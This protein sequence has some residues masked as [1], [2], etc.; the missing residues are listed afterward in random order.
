MQNKCSFCV[1]VL[2][3]KEEDFVKIQNVHVTSFKY[4]AILQS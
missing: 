3:K 4:V 2:Y 1:E